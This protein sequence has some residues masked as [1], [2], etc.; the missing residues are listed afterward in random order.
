MRIL[1]MIT[2]FAVLPLLLAAGCHKAATGNEVAANAAAP[3]DDAAARSAADA[4]TKASGVNF[5]AYQIS[6]DH[7]GTP[8]PKADFMGP[9]G[10]KAN[11]SQ[12]AGKPFLVVEWATNLKDTVAQLPSLDAL[13]AENK[14]AVVALNANSRPVDSFPDDVTPFLAKQNLHAL[15]DY[16]DPKFD[17]QH[18]LKSPILPIAY[19]YDSQGKE[20]AR[21]EWPVNYGDA[22]IRALL[23]E[24]K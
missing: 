24:A 15:K 12:F 3:V 16:R 1:N 4:A 22:K 17:V 7:A 6:R 21:I 8:A 19:L 23:A 10:A 9:G 11:F 2:P 20:V 18:E 14:I 5:S 13:A